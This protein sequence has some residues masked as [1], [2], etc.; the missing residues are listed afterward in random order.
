MNMRFLSSL[1]M[2]ALA[3][4]FVACE[5]DTPTTP[6]E[7][8]SAR[9]DDAPVVPGNSGV[10]HLQLPWGTWVATAY[11]AANLIVA[12]YEANE[13]PGCGGTATVENWDL[14]SVENGEIGHWIG[15]SG[16]IPV[17]VYRFSD[18]FQY[19]LC[20]VLTER[21][22]YVGMHRVTFNELYTVEGLAWPAVQ[23]WVSAGEVFDPEGNR[24]SFKELIQYRYDA[25]TD[26][27]TILKDQITIRPIGG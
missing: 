21:W 8:E 18:L 16:S 17:A 22:L 19:D 20:T 27:E 7:F 3:T 12:H 24:Y 13:D 25:E 6:P 11:P 4:G 23:K 10:M 5:T 1:L 14:L 9:L 2:L 26:V 15:Q